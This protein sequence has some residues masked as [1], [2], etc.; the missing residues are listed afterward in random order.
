METL[1]YHGI[2]KHI[3]FGS[4]IYHTEGFDQ[5]TGSRRRYANY[6]LKVRLRKQETGE[7]KQLMRD[8]PLEIAQR[9]LD[10][11]QVYDP[12]LV[13]PIV[14]MMYAGL[15]GGEVCNV[16]R[17][18]KD[19]HKGILIS[20]IS[21]EGAEGEEKQD[22]EAMQ[23]CLLREYSL[24][25]DNAFQGKIKCERIQGVYS[26]F[27]KTILHFYRYHLSLIKDKPCETIGG[28]KPMFL[29][30]RAEKNGV[31]MAMTISGLRDRITSLYKNYVLPSC[32]K[33][34][35][36]KLSLYYL[37][38]QG[39]TWGKHTFRHYYTVLLLYYGVDD[40]ILLKTLRGDRR[41]KSAE[42]YLR[43]KGVLLNLY[44]VSLSRIGEMILPKEV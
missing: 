35:D 9:F 1:A 36:P 15:R 23:I 31:Y 26:T 22:P 6:N 39:H 21:Y 27:L 3:K 11:A 40:P 38:M 2:S 44:K 18:V 24:R 29:N 33:D 7:L 25:S 20:V 41:I 17:G 16:F 34:P 4:L 42:R 32:E 12:E 14:L 5:T 13:F 28:I 10:M 8:M 19:G 30:Q 37:Q 43:D